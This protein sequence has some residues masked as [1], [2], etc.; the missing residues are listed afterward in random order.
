MA[1]PSFV[2]ES[3]G[4]TDAGGAWSGISY[5]P[6]AVGNI[7]VLQI[8]QDGTTSAAV[9]LTGVSSGLQALD[10]TSS[11]LT[12]I[13]EFAGG[14]CRQYLWIGRAAATTNQNVSGGNSTSEDIYGRFYE[15]TNVS[16]GTT[17]ATVIENGTAGAT[18]T[19]SGTSNT[20]ADAG[21]TT[22][23]VDRLALNFVAVNDDNAIS[24]FTGMTGGTWRLVTTYADSG[25]TDGAI[26]LQASDASI[27][28][29]NAADFNEIFGGS[30]T[31]EEQA[32]SFTAPL[33]GK[34]TTVAPLLIKTGTPTDDII[35]ELR[36][37]NAGVPS[38]T[39]LASETIPSASLA[40]ARNTFTLNAS[41][42]SG[43]LY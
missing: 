6:T 43:T 4:F 12:Y 33:T 32:Q 35:V 31:N 40:D 14:G 19:S 22:L 21:V 30:G 18:V 38:S 26:A 20:A 9:T 28:Q 13:G 8:L 17:L 16:T 2:A 1:I 29:A 36:S 41:V 15:F 5:A 42:T 10:G 7:I 37:D 34:L 3:T 23:G 39:V 25:G 27:D 24:A 11:A